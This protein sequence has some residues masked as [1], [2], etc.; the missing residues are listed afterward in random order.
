MAEGSPSSRKLAQFGNVFGRPR[1]SCCVI[2]RGRGVEKCQQF[3]ASND[4]RG[5]LCFR[6]AYNQFGSDGTDGSV[7]D[8]PCDAVERCKEARNLNQPAVSG[9]GSTNTGTGKSNPLDLS[10][11]DAGKAVKKLFGRR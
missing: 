9:G 2:S 1:T 5:P 11:T 3:A 4:M 8:G 6:M 7:R 10:R